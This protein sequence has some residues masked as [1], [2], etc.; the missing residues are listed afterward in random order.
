MVMKF[1]HIILYPAIIFKILTTA[2]EWEQA[3]VLEEGV[4]GPL[5]CLVLNFK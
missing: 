2:S 1:T 4:I 5:L 3:I